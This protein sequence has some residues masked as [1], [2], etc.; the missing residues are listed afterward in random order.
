MILV[1][2]S[3]FLSVCYGESEHFEGWSHAAMSCHVLNHPGSWKC[4]GGKLAPKS[5]QS[6]IQCFSKVMYDFW[7]SCSVILSWRC[8]VLTSG[9]VRWILA[10][11]RSLPSW[12]Q[13]GFVG[14]SPKLQLGFD[15]LNAF[16]WF[17][18]EPYPCP[19]PVPADVFLG[20]GRFGCNLCWILFD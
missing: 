3:V 5:T 13:L 18:E 6:Q 8:I 2:F 4:S 7:S 1:C 14:G 19:C 20:Y 15:G 11:C 12:S 17:G 9:C 16:M 10:L